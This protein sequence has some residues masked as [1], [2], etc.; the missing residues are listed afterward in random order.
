MNYR[1]VVSK[2]M[3]LQVLFLPPLLPLLSIRHLAP[4]VW[5]TLCT[6]LEVPR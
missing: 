3:D 2:Q 6:V 4:T 1:L 5:Q